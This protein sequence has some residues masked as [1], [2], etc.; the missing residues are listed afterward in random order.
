M[1]KYALAILSVVAVSAGLESSSAEDS[2]SDK[3]NILVIFIDDMGF[4]DPSCFGNPLIKTPHIDKLAAE[5]IKLTNF[6]V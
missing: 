1:N 2:N 4:A 3:P 6:Y 5:G